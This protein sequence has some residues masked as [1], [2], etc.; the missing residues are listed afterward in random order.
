MFMFLITFES[1]AQKSEKIWILAEEMYVNRII[2]LDSL[3]KI[4]TIYKEDD[5]AHSSE[6]WAYSPFYTLFK[7]NATDYDK[8]YVEAL[9]KLLPQM[10]FE[11]YQH[12]I[13]QKNAWTRVGE[14]KTLY[15][16]FYNYAT[17]NNKKYGYVESDKCVFESKINNPFLIKNYYNLVNRYLSDQN[18]PLRLIEKITDNQVELFLLDSLQGHFLKN[19]GVDIGYINPNWKNIWNYEYVEKKIDVFEKYGLFKHLSKKEFEKAKEEAHLFLVN[20][21]DDILSVFPKTRFFIGICNEK[22]SVKSIKEFYQSCFLNLSKISHEQFQIQNLKINYQRK[23][24]EGNESSGLKILYQFQYK[25][26]YYKS[27][28]ETGYWHCEP[29]CPVVFVRR[30]NEILREN[31]TD[32]QF[33]LI[34]CS[35]EENGEKPSLDNMQYG[36]FIFLD[37]KTYIALKK[38]KIFDFQEL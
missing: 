18:S 7:A 6:I 21:D 2:S 31:K 38:D 34:N 4:K 12:K 1:F 14:E 13:K 9:R 33:Y 29:C 5:Y 30:I 36:T 23:Y 16:D 24:K 17:I 10:R 25:N 11:A 19:K 28:I 20:E 22:H 3:K 32:G 35:Y 8:K 37:K 27:I 26:K 15:C